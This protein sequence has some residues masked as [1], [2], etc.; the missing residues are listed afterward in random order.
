MTPRQTL[1]LAMLLAMASAPAA[2]TLA[3]TPPLA[4]RL[5]TPRP[6]GYFLGDV[7]GYEVEIAVDPRFTLEPAS[8]PKAGPRA[9]WLDLRGVVVEEDADAGRR[10]YRLTVEHQTFYAPL[11]PKR[12]EIPGFSVF[13]SDGANRIR[14][15]IPAWSFIASPLREIIPSKDESGGL[16]RPDMQPAPLPMAAGR[17]ALAASGVTALLALLALACNRAWPPFHARRGRPFASALRRIARAA[18]TPADEAGR[19]AA[20]RDAALALHRAFDA[21]AG[22]RL[23]AGDAD[24]FFRLLPACLPLEPGVRRFFAASR[25]AFFA[26]ETAAAMAA[27]PLDD[28]VRLAGGLS[29]AERRTP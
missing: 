11:E 27:M 16:L 9:S 22:R 23:F 3:Q 6:F 29:A 10:R 20:W 14:A 15:D 13:L 19:E 28:L 5:T 18:R 17:R 8:T 1:P 21:A 26:G 24:L 7:I 4:A 25:Q 2:P 12:M